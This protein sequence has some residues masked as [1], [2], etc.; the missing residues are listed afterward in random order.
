VSH[1]YCK[2][3]KI[4]AIMSITVFPHT[5]LYKFKPLQHN[6]TTHCKAK[7]TP[8]ATKL[9]RHATADVGGNRATPRPPNARIKTKKTN[10]KKNSRIVSLGRLWFA[11]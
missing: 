1:F 6:T 9:G 7:V 4:S 3:T 11:I 2:N 5:N 8:R 10:K